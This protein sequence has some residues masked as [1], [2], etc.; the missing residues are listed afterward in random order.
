MSKI[1]KITDPKNLKTPKIYLGKLVKS[2]LIFL[3]KIT[4]NQINY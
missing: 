2:K 1:S 4:V 3:I